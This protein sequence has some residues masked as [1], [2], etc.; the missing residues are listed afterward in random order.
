[1]EASARVSATAAKLEKVHHLAAAMR[2]LAAPEA[3]VAVAYLSGELPQGRIGIGPAAIRA[4]WPDRAAAEPVLALL[5][6]D[7]A[8]ETMTAVAGRGS[9][10]QRARLLHALLAD[11]TQAEQDFLA[12]LLF[13]ELRQ[14]AQEGVML[15]AVAK[16]AG[17]RPAEVRRA[18][19]LAGDLPAVAGAALADGSA[20]L[21]AFGLRLFRPLQPM[22]AQSADGVGEAL[23][24][25]G[26]AG[27]EYK[28]DGARVQVHRQG[29]DV[30]VYTRRLNDV[31]DSV[32]EIVEAVRS[33]S[34]REL[35]L[36]GEAI[37]LRPDGSPL[38]FQQT[39]RRFG[40]K[41]DVERMRRELPLAVLFFDCLHV[42]G[43]TLLDRTS[44][45]RFDA[46]AANS[47]APLVVP[48]LV[49]DDAAA[50]DRFMDGARASGHEGLLAKSLTAVYEAGRR[51]A[52]WIKVKPANT[53]DLV[54]LAAEWGHGRR[55]G[56]LSNLHLGARD[57]ESGGFVMLGKTFKGMTDEVLAWQ[58]RVLPGLE[59]HRD[60]YTVYVRPELVVEVAFNEIQASS[61]YP[62][63]VALR[64]A[65]LKGYRPDKR[66]EEAD[67]IATVRALH[68]RMSGQTPLHGHEPG[69]SS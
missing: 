47:P 3:R 22:L 50:A 25:L 1:V 62:G 44:A 54:V 26:S 55:R 40:R 17:V 67:T 52:S 4:A 63:G 6:V 35:I 18:Y 29:D 31:S 32:P 48:R 14:G 59:T 49:T 51:G 64:F 57:P 42:D 28:L 19:M 69:T 23:E 65:R 45:D 15:E 10:G 30:R 9:T 41:L 2:G 36:D 24:R 37:T 34:A 43:E 33:L 58:T 61:R 39:M 66:P 53:L 38:P 56:W 16:A 27:F 20:G 5:A 46:L 13:G 11:A 68:G 7:A 12:R 60:D 21:A 8:F